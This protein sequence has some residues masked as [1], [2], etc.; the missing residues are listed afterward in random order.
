MLVNARYVRN[1]FSTV[2][3]SIHVSVKNQFKSQCKNLLFATSS[4][5]KNGVL[6]TMTSEDIV[7]K[8]KALADTYVDKWKQAT[9]ENEEE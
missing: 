9:N 1:I 6:V 4:F 7:R 2:I 8:A 3:K 5:Q